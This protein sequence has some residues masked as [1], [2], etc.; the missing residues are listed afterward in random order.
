LSFDPVPDSHAE[1]P[2]THTLRHHRFKDS[3][4]LVADHAIT[5][6]A[7]H[8][9]EARRWAAQRGRLHAMQGSDWIWRSSRAA[10]DAYKR[11]KGRGT[12]VEAL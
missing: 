3:A 8:D 5:K 12:A 6:H 9:V 11:I 2:A 7:P 10:V 1:T 4:Q